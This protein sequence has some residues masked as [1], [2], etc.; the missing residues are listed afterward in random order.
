[1][2]FYRVIT[3]KGMAEKRLSTMV[4]TPVSFALSLGRIALIMLLFYP[5]PHGE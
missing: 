5:K 1:V 2:F 4:W 3:L